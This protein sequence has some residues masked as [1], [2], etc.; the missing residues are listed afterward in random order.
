MIVLG[1]AEQARAV[2]AQHLGAARSHLIVAERCLTAAGPTLVPADL[3]TRAK[4]AIEQV[5]QLGLVIDGLAQ[6][7]QQ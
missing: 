2:A 7:K 6:A 5:E 4:G 3:I 1:T